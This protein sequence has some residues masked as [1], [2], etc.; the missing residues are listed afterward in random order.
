MI[1]RGLLKYSLK[2]IWIL[3]LV[4]GLALAFALVAGISGS[5]SF[6]DNRNNSS[7]ITITGTAVDFREY[8][9]HTF[10]PLIF[11]VYGLTVTIILVMEEVN[12]GALES[13]LTTPLSRGQIFL[14]R[15]LSAIMGYLLIVVF[16]FLVQ[17]ILFGAL[18]RDFKETFSVLV[19]TDLSLYMSGFL[20]LAITW[21]LGTLFKNVLVGSLVISALMALFWIATLLSTFALTSNPDSSFKILRYFTIFSLV[22]DGFWYQEATNGLAK[23]MPIKALDFAWQIP[24]MLVSGNVLLYGGYKIFNYQ[25]FSFN[26]K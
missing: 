18:L 5:N 3:I 16:N 17:L 11:I 6:A 13:W 12:D 2:R 15:T 21:I 19:L 7:G 14:T 1:N 4:C 26:V 22:N 20:T 23:L 25:S 24:T 10:A 8:F 9:L